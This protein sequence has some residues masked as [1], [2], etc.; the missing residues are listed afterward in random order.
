MYESLDEIWWSIFIQSTYYDIK[1]EPTP[2]FAEIAELMEPAI[3]MQLQRDRIL[4]V[5]SQRHRI[6]E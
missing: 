2:Q 3:H 4:F 6:R 5:P 1:S